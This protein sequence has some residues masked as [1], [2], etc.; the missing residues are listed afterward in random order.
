METHNGKRSLAETDEFLKT[1]EHA[2]REREK[3]GE[4]PGRLAWTLA[5]SPIPLIG[6]IAAWR[7]AY[8][9]ARSTSLGDLVMMGTSTSDYEDGIFGKILAFRGAGYMLIP[10][11]VFM[12]YKVLENLFA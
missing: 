12:G 8:H 3:L 1:R 2:L 6:E 4:A 11:G 9:E 7:I 10:G 5:L